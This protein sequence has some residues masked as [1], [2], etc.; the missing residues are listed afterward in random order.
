MKTFPTFPASRA[1]TPTRRAEKLVYQAMEASDLDGLALYEVKPLSTAPQ[2]DFAVWLLDIGTF[3]IQVKGGRYIIIDGEWHL[4]TDRGQI[5]KESPIPGTWDAA[6]A[7]HD[8]IQEQL[9]HRTFVIPVLVLTDMEPDAE[10]EALARS[11]SVAVHW[12]SPDTLVEH[13]VELAEERQVY[14]RPTAAGIAAEAG[15]VLPGAGRPTRTPEPPAAPV[16]QIHIHVEHLHIHVAGP[17]VLAD[18]QETAS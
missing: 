17:E 12:G 6:M 15:L 9:R 13:L 18:L 5:R 1:D 3:G 2:L 14:V 7:I 8:L 16:Q 4:I 11:R 10:I